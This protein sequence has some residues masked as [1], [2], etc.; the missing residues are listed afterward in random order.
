MHTFTLRLRS[1]LYQGVKALAEREGV[2]M[3]ELIAT[4]VA[5]KFSA[6]RTEDYLEERSSRGSRERFQA[7]L[8]KVPDVEP[9]ERDRLD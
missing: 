3:N 9:E 2:S 1:S 4:T 8:R 7:V 5:E 6:F